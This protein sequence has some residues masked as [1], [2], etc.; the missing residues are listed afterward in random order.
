MVSLLAREEPVFPYSYFEAV[1]KSEGRQ[2]W[3]FYELN[4]CPR[5]LLVPMMQLST[6]AA[7]DA[8]G[9]Q[10]SKTVSRLVA[11]I[12]LSIRR[13]EYQGGGLSDLVFDGLETDEN[14][15]HIERDRFHC[16]EAFR[17]ALLIYV[18]RV[19]T[20]RRVGL[21]S[22]GYGSSDGGGDGDSGGLG[23]NDEDADRQRKGVRSRLSFLA[24]VALEHVQACRPD[25][26][27]QKQV[28]FPV[29]V[30]GAETRQIAHRTA[31]R[32]VCEHWY[33]RF[34][35]QMYKTVLDV[36]EAVWARHDAGDDTYWWGD[37]LDA[38]RAVEGDF[39]QFCFG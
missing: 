30:A 33:A 10:P 7:R 23:V 38:R 25:D 28:L 12:E 8:K 29:F 21:A 15:L 20:M 9:A 18:L 37:E 31:I 17:Y 34:G 27:I 22:S 16:C 36:L 14:D 11:E 39:V 2:P 13:Y 35:Y 26:M 3:T 6:L 24:R 32:Q 4:G 19:F 5:E 1:L